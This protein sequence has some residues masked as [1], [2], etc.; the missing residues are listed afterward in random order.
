MEPGRFCCER[1]AGPL[2]AVFGKIDIFLTN[3]RTCSS[4]SVLRRGNE[5]RAGGERSPDFVR[6]DSDQV[7][8]S[9]SVIAAGDATRGRS[10]FGRRRQDDRAARARWARPPPA[11]RR[12]G[13]RRGAYGG[14]GGERKNCPRGPRN[15]LKRLIPD[16]EIK[17]NSKEN[18]SVFQTIPRIFQAFY[19]EIKGDQRLS[20]G[21][22]A[23]TA[24]A[25]AGARWRRRR[26]GAR[27]SRD[28]PAPARRTGCR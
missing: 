21:K 26:T 23:S 24:S 25:T 8:P 6:Q 13:G 1:R 11:G 10:V 17:V 18:P 12:R 3:G 22:R 19:K 28:R 14:I 9:R 5:R 7:E 16:M 27:P 15:P 4:L 2:R 20:K